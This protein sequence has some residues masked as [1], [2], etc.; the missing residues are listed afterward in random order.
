MALLTGVTFSKDAPSTYAAALLPMINKA[1]P[2]ER[3]I[4]TRLK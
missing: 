4:N 1:M 3:T 2:P